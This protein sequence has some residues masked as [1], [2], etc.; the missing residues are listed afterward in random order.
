M[1]NRIFFNKR[2]GY[3]NILINLKPAAKL[4]N[5]QGREKKSAL[6]YPIKIRKRLRN[7]IEPF[8]PFQ[9]T[10]LHEKKPYGK[11]RHHSRFDP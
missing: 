4:G 7:K 1:I 3:E 11:E 10:L 8:S 5:N 6:F 9:I 2:D